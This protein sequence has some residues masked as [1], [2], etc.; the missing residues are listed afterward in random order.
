MPD[1][2]QLRFDAVNTPDSSWWSEGGEKVY[3][4]GDRL[5]MHA[6]APMPTPGPVTGGGVCTA[7]CKQPL[8]ENLT[9]ELEAH[10]ISSSIDANN[11]NLFFCYADPSGKPLYDTRNDRADAG[12]GRYHEL[13]GHII[14]FLNGNEA[15]SPRAE[16]GGFKARVRIRR[17]PGFQ[18]LAETFAGRCRQEETYA[19]RIVKHGGEIV[20]S[21]N[22]AEYLRATDPNPLGGGLL[23][24][25]TFR[26]RLW[27]RNVRVH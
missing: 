3:A 7:W 20:F 14:T 9:I 19:L 8:P 13:N 2:K 15:G 24:L 16:D 12:Y 27:W 6:D 5:F 22:G 18:L 10:V 1:W 11:I 26:T 17:C 21:V 4:E 23:G 25:R